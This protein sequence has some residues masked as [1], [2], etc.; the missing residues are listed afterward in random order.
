MSSKGNWVS[1]G[2]DM[3]YPGKARLILYYANNK[4]SAQ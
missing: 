2:C 3:A 1:I 4:V